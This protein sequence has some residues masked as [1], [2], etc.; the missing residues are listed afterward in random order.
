MDDPT[1]PVGEWFDSH[2][3]LQERYLPPASDDGADGDAA[4]SAG[5]VDPDEIAM[6]K[7][8]PQARNSVINYGIPS[9]SGITISSMQF[10]AIENAVRQA[11]VQFEPRI[12]QKTLAV[13]V[14]REAGFNFQHNSL[15][16]VIR[17][18]MWN[19]PVPLELLLS[20]DV[21]VETGL[22]AVRDMRG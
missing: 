22:A 10:E 14:N 16:L 8:S 17:G 9:L 13:E 19:Q 4:G 1:A 6:W 15:R 20:A 7:E 5:P 11:I 21:D 18:H 3:H 12:D 2:C